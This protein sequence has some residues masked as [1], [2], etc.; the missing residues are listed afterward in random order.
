MGVASSQDKGNRS[1][2]NNASTSKPRL[3]Q[4]LFFLKQTNKIIYILKI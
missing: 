3:I 1:D 2:S 4:V